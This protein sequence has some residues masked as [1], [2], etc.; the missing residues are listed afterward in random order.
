MLGNVFWGWSKISPSKEDV[1]S[2]VTWGHCVR[3]CPGEDINTSAGGYSRNQCAPDNPYWIPYEK[4]AKTIGT[5][6]S[7][8]SIGR[9]TDQSYQQ[10]IFCKFSGKRL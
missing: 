7:P 4:F 2:Q 1:C 8:V 10:W 3:G 6:I 5:E 9:R